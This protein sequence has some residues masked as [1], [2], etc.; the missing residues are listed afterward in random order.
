MVYEGTRQNQY[1]GGT[2]FKPD[3]V[4]MKTR[5]ATG[6]SVII[7]SVRG[8]DNALQT[9]TTSYENQYGTAD[10]KITA[11]NN[12]GFTLGVDAAGYGLN[13]DGVDTVAWNWDMGGTTA[14]NTNGTITIYSQ[15]YRH[16]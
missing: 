9:S 6:N 2:G 15:S 4:W 10:D 13:N 5:S 16:R 1:I 8:R 12:D 7:D 11:F 14:S 3:L